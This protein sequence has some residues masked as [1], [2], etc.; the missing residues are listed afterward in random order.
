MKGTSVLHERP[1]YW[2]CSPP[3]PGSALR[4]EAK[5][6]RPASGSPDRSKSRP[7]PKRAKTK[8][9]ERGEP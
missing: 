9:G 4:T 3:R 5:K 2:A 8:P 1:W 6:D 7:I